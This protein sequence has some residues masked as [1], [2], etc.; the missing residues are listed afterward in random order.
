MKSGITL[1]KALDGGDAEVSLTENNTVESSCGKQNCIVNWKAEH[2]FVNL[3]FFE[4]YN[5]T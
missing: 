4:L 3:G 2:F 1:Y 5:T